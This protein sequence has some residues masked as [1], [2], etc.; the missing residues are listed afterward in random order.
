[1]RGD[2]Q[3]PGGK[4]ELVAPGRARQRRHQQLYQ[5]RATRRKVVH[6]T[7]DVQR[8]A[9]GGRQDIH[10]PRHQRATAQ[11]HTQRCRA[12]RLP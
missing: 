11:E 10:V 6:H 8:D 9:R 7:A 3:Q 2:F 1:M 5:A 4:D 12:Q